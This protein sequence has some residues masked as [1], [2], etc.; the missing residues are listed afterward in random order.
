M[1]KRSLP[2]TY[3]MMLF[4]IGLI[5]L[6]LLVMGLV[7]GYGQAVQTKEALASKASLSAS[8]FARMPLVAEALE[9]GKASEE[10]RAL[11]KSIRESHQLQY[12]VIVDMEGIRL[13][14]PVEERIGQHFVGG[15]VADVLEGKTYTSEAV[16]TLGPSMR[17][18]EPVFHQGRQIGAVSVGIST[19]FIE[20]AVWESIRST[21]FGTAISLM[22]GL[23]GS[24][25]LASR[26]KQTLFNLEPR[27]IAKMMQERVAMLESV[28]EGIV[29]VNADQ[30]IIITNR[31][32]EQLLRTA[33]YHGSLEGEPIS[34]VWPDLTLD[35][36][37]TNKEAVYD[38]VVQ[39]GQLE[40]M[41]SSVPVIVD[42][43]CVGALVTFRDRNELDAVMKKLSGVESY[44]HTLRMQT[45][46]FMNKL[47]I[48][49]AMVYTESY[50][51][52]KDYVEHLSLNYQ[53]ETGRIS[54][55]IDDVAIAGF[56]LTQIERLEHSKITIELR[57]TRKWPTLD[58]PVMVDRWIT[59]IGNSLENA[60][61]AMVGQTHKQVELTF[62]VENGQL[63]YQ[64]RDNGRGFPQESLPFLLEKGVST[65]GMNRGYGMSIMIKAIEAAD[66]SFHVASEPGVGTIFRVSMPIT[67]YKNKTGDEQHD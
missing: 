39:L 48:I 4:S 30:T 13:T 21:F 58:D 43:E 49:S 6:T 47:H 19:E 55:H 32:A 14:H 50:D 41:T 35:T 17:A 34:R 26:L 22:L 16:G 51:E 66:G 63:V 10:L 46:E 65:K 25:V 45:H 53:K 42:E 33:G 28:G 60:V 20:G 15:D 27:E 61:E 5:C 52:L 29:A 56:V 31:A 8:H 57:G 9:A 23:L 54:A 67:T 24:Y 38:Q 11:A 2:L 12:I 1:R 40:M 64:L 59:I 7:I 44:A 18:F 62:E 36:Q 37:I 3:Q